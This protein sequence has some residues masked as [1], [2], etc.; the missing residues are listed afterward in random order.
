MSVNEGDL[1]VTPAQAA[2]PEVAQEAANAPRAGRG[3]SWSFWLAVAWVAVLVLS[4]IFADVLP[5]AGFNEPV[6]PGASAP[7]HELGEFLGTDSIGRSVLSRVIYGA[8]VS[9]TVSLMATVIGLAVGTLLGLLAAY[10]GG[11][12]A[13]VINGGRDA[14]LAFPTL[15]MLLAVAAVIEPTMWSLS[16]L[17]GI[18]GVPVCE[19]IAYAN[20]LAQLSRDYVLAA[21]VVGVPSSRILFR[22]VLPNIVNPLIAF[23][24]IQ[25]ALF[26]VVEGALDYLGVGVVPPTPSWG[27]MISEGLPLLQRTPYLVLVPA[28]VLFVTVLAFNTIGERLRERLEE[29]WVEPS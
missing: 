28:C 2:G 10:F 13:T 23:G 14:L 9:L 5:I 25:V 15:V 6:A 7:F 16:I 27:A 21:R 26:M 24:F 22:E 17:L 29:R 18:V 20:A 3:R 12:V 1:A 11:A 4:A 8:R 19:R